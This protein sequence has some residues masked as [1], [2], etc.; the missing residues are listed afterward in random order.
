MP[1]RGAR[2]RGYSP[3][4]TTSRGCLGYSYRNDSIGSSPEARRAGHTPNTIPTA[5]A[6]ENASTNEA[7]ATEVFHANARWRNTAVAPAWFVL[8]FGF[9]A[10]VAIVFGVWPARRASGLDPI[11]SLRYE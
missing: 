10:A 9:A 4:P 7:G 3:P 11:E 2:A 8:A 6:N 5:A 1:A